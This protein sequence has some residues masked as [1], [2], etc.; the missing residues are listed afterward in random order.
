M[1]ISGI[2]LSLTMTDL[3]LAISNTVFEP[4]DSVLNVPL[5]LHEPMLLIESVKLSFHC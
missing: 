2:S 5:S 3:L 1:Y 4:T